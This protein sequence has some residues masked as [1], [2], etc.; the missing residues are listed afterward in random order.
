MRKIGKETE[1]QVSVRAESKE[2]G[3]LVIDIRA[4]GGGGLHVAMETAKI[5]FL[6]SLR[7]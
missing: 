5:W 7:K 3:V 6:A 1:K 4:Q 2:G